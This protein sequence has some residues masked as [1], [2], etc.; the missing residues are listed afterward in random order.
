MRRALFNEDDAKQARERRL[1]YQGTARVKISEIGFDSANYIDDKN[2]ERLCGIF[3]KSGCRRFDV[4][5]HIPATVSR[6][7][8]AE[9]LQ[10]AGVPARALLLSSGEDTPFLTFSRGQL[11]GLHGRHRLSAGARVLAPLERWWTVDLFLDDISKDLRVSLV[12]E[13]SNQKKLTDG[14]IYWTIRQY[15]SEGSS[16]L[17]QKWFTRLSDWKQK[18]IKQL[19]REEN[20]QL[21]EAFD[22]LLTIQGLWYDGMRLGMIH[23]LIALAA[24]E[25]I[26]T[27]FDHIYET[28]LFFVNGDRGSLNRIDTET[29]LGLQLKCPRVCEKDRKEVNGLVLSGQV[30]SSFS[31][32]ERRNICRRLQSF[33]GII[34][35]LYTF[36]EDF[37]YL[38][39]CA[40]CIR[41]LFG[42]VNGSIW[43]TMK[44]MFV[45]T[46]DEDYGIVQTSE[47][48]F[49]R[50]T[51]GNNERLDLGYRQLWLYAMRNYRL[52]PQPAK[53]EEEL[54][55]KPSRREADDRVLYEMAELARR[56]GFW[57]DE[58]RALLDGSPDRQIA[59]AALLQAR[60]PDQ[61]QYDPVQLEG[62]VDRVVACFSAAI[63]YVRQPPELLADSEVS[64]RARRGLPQVKAHAQDAPHLFLDKVHNEVTSS[65]A[66]LT[67]FFVR[68]CVYFAFFGKCSLSGS[69]VRDLG[70]GGPPG[71]TPGLFVNENMQTTGASSTVPESTVAQGSGT[72]PT[73]EDIPTR[74]RLE[75]HSEPILED[76]VGRSSQLALSGENTGY[77]EMADEGTR[78]HSPANQVATSG[79]PESLS[80]GLQRVSSADA[81]SLNGEQLGH[82]NAEQ[83]PLSRD[84]DWPS[85]PAESNLDTSL[86]EQPQPMD[87]SPSIYSVRESG[88]R[89]TGTGAERQYSQEL[90]R[91]IQERER[92]DNDWERERLEQELGL[93]TSSSA[94][95]E[96]APVQCSKE[97][98]VPETLRQTVE[99]PDGSDQEPSSSNVGTND[100][101]TREPLTQGDR[102]VTLLDIHNSALVPSGRQGG[103]SPTAGA[104]EDSRVE[105]RMELVEF[106][107]WSLERGQWRR[108]DHLWVDPADTFRVELIAK[109]YIWKDFSLYDRHWNSLSPAQCFRAATVDGSNAIFV[110]S[111]D[112]ERRLQAEGRRMK[113][114][115]I[116]AIS[117][118]AGSDPTEP[119]RQL[120]RNRL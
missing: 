39:C 48:S 101:Q 84:S 5:H 50:Q 119:E 82:Q 74:Q 45:G 22:R 90:E 18:R 66:T 97:D 20:R 31:E 89:N 57:S 118:R 24:T 28:Y 102:P 100:Q 58:I 34:P 71:D 114:T 44:H 40:Q 49:R 11:V 112:E 42:Q 68:R 35:S 41:R 63:E 56:L 33:D 21:R 69:R 67:T 92:L 3:R 64:T 10:K 113:M 52:L 16:L 60:K 80:L 51:A 110:V 59:R 76:G 26:L 109:K 85:T 7:A 88:A 73:H 4:E 96:I 120:K 14:E 65:S 9:A 2:V 46:A 1:K 105:D 6:N 83:T 81:S 95:G 54:L 98:E 17:R 30:F 72:R 12:E 29:V 15:E 70:P 94:Q 79:I 86:G 117:H 87:Y 25:E 77:D 62:L 13:Y 103:Q 78:S 115:Q 36:W 55:V 91:A 104:F 116:Q 19:D 27:Y 106:T 32:S 53:E 37:K 43:N 75:G 107:F 38:E 61:F 99:P 111:E 23:R 108:A 93:P 8:L 47:F